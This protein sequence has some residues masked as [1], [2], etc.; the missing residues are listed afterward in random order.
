MLGRRSLP[1]IGSLLLAGYLLLILLTAVCI[2]GAQT[3]AHQHQG[4]IHHQHTP[5]CG[6]AHAVG[7]AVLLAF[8]STLLCLYPRREMVFSDL[9]S[10]CF[11]FRFPLYGRA[12]PKTFLPVSFA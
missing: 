3:P 10:V 1:P 5:L 12:P 11:S 9:L 2:F 6:W 8:S 4:P 7:A